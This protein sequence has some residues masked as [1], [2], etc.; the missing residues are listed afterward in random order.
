MY[1]SGVTCLTEHL[2]FTFNMRLYYMLIYYLYMYVILFFKV[3]METDYQLPTNFQSDPFFRS[4]H[5]HHQTHSSTILCHLQAMFLSATYH[6]FLSCP[7][8]LLIME[9]R[10]RQK[11]IIILLHLIIDEEGKTK[12]ETVMSEGQM[13]ILMK[14][15]RRMKI[16]TDKYEI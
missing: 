12:M 4:H 13:K 3:T 8:E 2:S 15:G 1:Q 10:N 14:E 5:H 6:H 9:D 16:L 7:V 11:T